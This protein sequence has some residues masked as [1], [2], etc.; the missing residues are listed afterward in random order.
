MGD[1]KS[2]L[3]TKPKSRI[4]EVCCLPRLL[5][6]VRHAEGPVAE[7]FPV[8]HPHQQFLCSVFRTS[9][10][11]ILMSV[12]RLER[13]QD[14]AAFNLNGLFANSN[15]LHSQLQATFGLAAGQCSELCRVCQTQTPNHT[16]QRQR[17]MRSPFGGYFSRAHTF[18]LIMHALG[19]ERLDACCMCIQ[20]TWRA[21]NCSNVAD[22][23]T[24]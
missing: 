2:N 19:L 8:S 1:D 20:F 22:K 4:L 23:P 21:T 18:P 14:A 16:V 15:C 11:R 7:V 6:S 3:R 12:N 5:N 24:R 17:F 10:T 9:Q 13:N